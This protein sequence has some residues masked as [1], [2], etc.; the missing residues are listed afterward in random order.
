ML[1]GHTT[2][3][4]VEASLNTWYAG[5]SPPSQPAR[6]PQPRQSDPSPPAGPKSPGLLVLEHELSNETVRAFV[7]TYPALRAHG[8]AAV[9]AVQLFGGA[10][11]AGDVLAGVSAGSAGPSSAS[12][13]DVGASSAG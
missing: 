5:T 1:G 13:A 4:R 2:L 8:W 7:D 12:S 6:S 3:P 9:S 11:R 10:Y